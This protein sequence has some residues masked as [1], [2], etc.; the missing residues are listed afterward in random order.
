MMKNQ[1]SSPH[2]SKPASTLMIQNY[3]LKANNNPH[4]KRYTVKV[5]SNQRIVNKQ[6]KFK[7]PLNS[8]KKDAPSEIE[9]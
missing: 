6:A 9:I 2:H 3:A 4:P 1:I 8:F 7:S 5:L